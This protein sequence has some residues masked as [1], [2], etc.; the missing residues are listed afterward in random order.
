MGK[1][2]EKQTKTIENQGKNQTSTIKEH[3]KQR[4]ESY[5][6]GKNDFNIERSDA[7]DEKQKEIFDRLVK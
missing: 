2:F 7:L 1:A 4:I 3:G 6:V 5:M